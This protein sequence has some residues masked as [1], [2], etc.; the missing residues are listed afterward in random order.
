M[1]ENSGIQEP[2]TTPNNV[3]LTFVG[4]DHIKIEVT[5]EAET[6]NQGFNKLHTLA[7]E[8]RAA[9]D[10]YDQIA[11]VANLWSDPVTEQVPVP[12]NEVTKPVG[13]TANRY[14]DARLHNM[15][16]LVREA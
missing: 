14:S 10:G 15:I 16:R 9:A 4:H 13:I 7:E 2:R 5:V 11:E 1:S 6:F 3:K 12:E 8:L